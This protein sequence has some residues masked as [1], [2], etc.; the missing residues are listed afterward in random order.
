MASARKQRLSI[1]ILF[2][3]LGGMMAGAARAQVVGPLLILQGADGT[4][5]APEVAIYSS[6]IDPASAQSIEGLGSNAFQVQESGTPVTLTGITYQPVGLAVVVVV[7]RGGISAPGNPRLKQ[8]T[9]LVRELVNRLSVTGAPEDDI[10]AI[11]GVGEGGVLQPEENFTYNPVDTNLVLNALIAMEGETIR[12]GTPLYEGLDEALRLLRNN[13]DETI[14]NVL[15]H[16]RKVILV[17]SDGIDPNFSDTAREQDIIR[18]SNE[19]SISIYAVGMA[20]WGGQLNR[21]AEGNLKRLAAQTDGLY[22]LHNSDAARADVLAFFDRLMTQRNQ[23]VLTYMTRQPKGLY[24]LRVT[25][26]TDTG[27]AEREISFSSRLEPMQLTITEPRDGITIAVPF[28]STV[29]AYSGQVT[30]RALLETPDGVP[31]PSPTVRYLI[32]GEWVGDGTSPPDYPFTW[33]PGTGIPVTGRSQ[34]RELTIQAEVTDPFLGTRVTSQQVK[35]QVAYEAPPFLWRAILW[36]RNFWWLLLV[37][38]FLVIGLVVLLFLLLRTR[39][40]VAQRIV[41]GTTGVLKGVTRR[42]GPAAPAPAKLVIIQ[43]ANVGRELR[44]SAQMMK[45]G[46]DP[47]FCDFALYD[48]YVSNPHFSI[49]QEQTQF[50]IV[51]EGSTNGTKVNGMPIPPHQRVILPPDAV[52]EVGQTRLQFKRIGGTTRYLG[53]PPAPTPGPQPPQAPGQRGGPTRKVTP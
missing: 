7:D 40:Q 20:P 42:L 46:R 13:P 6:V 48:E 50:Y 36:V 19:A 27:S 43:G 53:Q 41:A 37:L 22:M 25:V 24:T 47:Q 26:S 44:L 23:Y 4:S 29:R 12:G 8:A 11:V 38:F 18:K 33:D 17:F 5:R 51:D 14:R 35:V 49:H 9:D 15:A 3:L 39:S 16:R 32:N 10:I 1:L 30:L 31:R 34:T 45:V 52:I 21:D 28:S 2:L